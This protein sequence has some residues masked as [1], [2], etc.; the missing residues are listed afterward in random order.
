MVM[1]D[2][3]NSTSIVLI[4]TPDQQLV[5]RWRQAL[6]GRHGVHWVAERTALDQSLAKLRPSVL[7]LDLG[8]TK[9][10]E[11]HSLIR[12]LQ[13]LSPATKVIVFAS[14][15]N[16]KEGASVLKA[17]ARGYGYKTIKPVL[18][19]KAVE[20]VEKGEMWIPRGLASLLVEELTVFAR[21]AEEI[22]MTAGDRTVDQ[23]T[24]RQREIVGLI[25]GGGSNKE[26]ASLL[27]IAERTVKAHLTETYRKLGLSDRLRLC[28]FVKDRCPY[29][30]HRE[31]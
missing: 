7:L 31:C 10:G 18:L 14:A 8:L 17:G 5:K 16:D 11:I 29:L 20:L 27:N 3:P 15:P 19:K 1:T 12:V 6:R 9:A 24:P 13:D 28:L 25:A 26:I 21:R 2:Q 4:G 23:L 22:S 30:I